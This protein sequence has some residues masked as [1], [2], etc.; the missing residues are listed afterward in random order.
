M[1][2]IGKKVVAFLCALLVVM[3]S[4]A[5]PFLFRHVEAADT[6]GTTEVVTFADFGVKDN[7]YGVKMNSAGTSVSLTTEGTCGKT[8]LDGVLFHGKVKFSEEAP[9][10]I[11][12]FGNKNGWLGL[13]LSSTAEGN[14]TLKNFLKGWHSGTDT[15]T[16]AV[17]GTQLTGAEI[18][19][20]M[21][22]QYVDNDGDGVK[23]DVKL[24]VWF[25][26]KLYDNKYIYKD[27]A[28]DYVGSYI[29]IFGDKSNTNAT[30]TVASVEDTPDE[31]KPD[32]GL[33]EITFKNFGVE[34]NTYGV[35]VSASGSVSLSA[36]GKY[37]ETGMDGILFHG[38]VTFSEEAPFT[39]SFF[40]NKNG[41]LGLRLSSTAEGNLTLKNFLKGWH[42]GTDTFT[43]AVAGTQLTGAEIDLK[44]SVQYVDNDG[45][46]VKDD[47]KLGVWFNDKLYDN[48]YIYKD[49]AADY[50]GGYIGIFGDK[51]NTNAAVTVASVGDTPEE[52]K[53]DESLKE[54]TFAHFGVKSDVYR[55]RMS[56]QWLSLS[57]QGIYEEA[58]MDGILFHGEV[59]YS[60][61]ASSTI[62]FFG[63]DSAW[64]GL[65]F[66]STADGNLTLNFIKVSA[67]AYNKTF[68]SDIAGTKL[69]G[70]K[71]DLKMSVQYVDQDQDGVKDDVKLGVWFN[72]KLYENK[73]IYLDGAVD[74]VGNYIGIF[75]DKE[76]S[77]VTV[78]SVGE[79][80]PDIGKPDE[81]L[82]EITFAHFRVRDAVY[83]H[84]M[85]GK[86]VALSTQGIYKE[87]DMD[88]ILFHGEVL[89]SEA[90]PSTISFFGKDS[91][92]KGLRLSS[93]A[94]GNL[95]LNFIKVSTSAYNK[96]F[97]SDIAGTKLTG[98]KID[99]KMSVQ[100]VDQD[101]DGVKDDVKLGVWFND[102]LYDN[103][104][105]YLDGAVDYVGSYIGIY[106]DKEDS[107]VAVTS[108]GEDL[109]RVWQTQQPDDSFKKITFTHF[110]VGNGTYV[111]DGGSA[112]TVSGQAEGSLDRTVL[113]GR[114]YL[115]EDEKIIITVGGKNN[116]WYGIRF[117]VG[118]DG[119]WTLLWCGDKVNKQY[120][121]MVPLQAGCSLTGQWL[122]FMM[123]TEIVDADDDG[124]KD[125]VKLG[126]WFNGS[127]YQDEYF[128]I[129][130]QGYELGSYFGVYCQA[131]DS[132]V[133]LYSIPELVEP[134]N[135]SIFGLSQDWENMLL[136]TGTK[137]TSYVGGSISSSPYNGDMEN[138]IIA[139]VI[140]LIA[141]SGLAIGVL[142][143][144]RKKCAG[145]KFSE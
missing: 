121:S 48:K 109:S 3:A 7:I 28:A 18:D 39:I 143:L 66:S 115:P 90:A 9:I 122:D 49:G 40:G 96:T 95:T 70:E 25:N 42:S 47:V 71:I 136:N 113:C 34:D 142:F 86:W 14:L 126:V 24:G 106:C 85:S 107:T 79:N 123:S 144:R 2:T 41:W 59:L 117:V 99:L 135:Y 80:L 5:E 104:Y 27:G 139:I 101:Q 119:K 60:E 91:G 137:K 52:E 37:E 138:N 140:A 103:Q 77:T 133:T 105:I 76:D 108:V 116:M 4:V 78:T 129:L 125:D 100:Y 20:K 11:S 45:D 75:C 68:K 67:S 33:K 16:P 54:I 102:V 124:Q 61:A 74:Y 30:V 26:D 130:D 13:R 120:G 110:G 65:R 36:D 83:R 21:S 58:D 35:N 84:C 56:G 38:R 44:M 69:T 17:A 32:E 62:S 51:S 118:K 22:V 114:I 134:F 112:M 93:T 64:K 92:W 111:S 141:S 8:N 57:T 97:K 131:K 10:T 132:Y 19:L 23:D 81:G 128:M 15:F 127:L 145:I 29:G 46:G 87:A 6:E 12:F 53:P 82:K 94:D 43:P 31:E 89:Y 55:N 88:G 73:Y 1:K 98:E 50:V 63:K 72:D